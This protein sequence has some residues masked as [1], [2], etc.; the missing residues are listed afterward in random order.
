MVGLTR[1]T[2]L[3]ALAGIAAHGASSS[4][5]PNFVVIAGKS[6]DAERT[7]REG[8][9]FNNAFATTPLELP[10]ITSILTGRYVHSHR[11]ASNGN[12]ATLSPRLK[13]F[14]QLLHAAGYET[15]TARIP[16]VEPFSIFLSGENPQV[17]DA[18]RQSGQLDRTVVIVTASCGN[19][20]RSSR[21]ASIRVPLSIRYPK[22]IK[23]D[24]TADAMALNV[25][26]APTILELAG[27]RLP[28]NLH[29][30]SLVPAM[31]GKPKTWRQAFLIEYFAD[32]AVPDLPTWVGVR[33]E[34]WKYT[35]Y[36]D[37]EGKDEIYDLK[38]DPNEQKNLI[39]E[40]EG[41]EALLLLRPELQSFMRTTT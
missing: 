28:N 23:P 20:S 32:P 37:L 16:A 38:N 34:R 12:Y 18:L 15:S 14:P 35:R 1:R 36:V 40:P 4:R 9:T 2:A 17:L 5:R 10:S 30:R 19:P 7:A 26:I 11:I 3:G 13:T 21:E 25:D 33:T 31:K 29:G 6:A 8:L 24:R 39:N 27:V 41:Q 22:L